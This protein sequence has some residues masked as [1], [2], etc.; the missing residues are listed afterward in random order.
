MKEVDHLMS[1]A[2]GPQISWLLRIDDSDFCDPSTS[3]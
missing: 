2:H 1:I 3:L